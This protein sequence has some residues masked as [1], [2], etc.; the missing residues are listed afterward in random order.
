MS[1]ALLMLVPAPMLLRLKVG[2]SAWP[3]TTTVALPSVASS[4][5]VSARAST[6]P[7][8]VSVWLPWRMV[9]V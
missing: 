6:T 2:F 8:R 9:M 7:S 4:V 3:V 1:C 5:S